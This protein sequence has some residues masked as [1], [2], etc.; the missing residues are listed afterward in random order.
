MEFVLKVVLNWEEI[1]GFVGDVSASEQQ[2]RRPGGALPVS[3]KSPMWSWAG[4]RTPV[5]HMISADTRD[6]W[7]HC[8]N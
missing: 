4:V 8:Q 2:G 6:I 7:P 1:Y 5:S 3:E